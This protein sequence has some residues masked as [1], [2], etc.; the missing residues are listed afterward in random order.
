MANPITSKDFS[1]V[2]DYMRSEHIKAPWYKDY[3]TNKIAGIT[4]Y[5]NYTFALHSADPLA[6]DELLMRL[7]IMPK[8]SHFYPNGDPQ[9]LHQALQLESRTRH[10][11]V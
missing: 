8:P 3:F 6:N 10:G 5:D 2:F 4:V 9:G 11:T 1:F 7:N